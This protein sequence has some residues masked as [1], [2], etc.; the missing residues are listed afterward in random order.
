MQ[1]FEGR[2]W[3]LLFLA[4]PVL[5][6]AVF[7]FAIFDIG[8]FARHWLPENIN[9]NGR[10]IDRLFMFILY[11]TGVI[12]VGTSMALF[13]F[14]WKYD[15]KT[16]TTEVTYTH[17]SHT[18]E[19]VW[20][21]LP[22]AALLFI[23]I[24]QMREWS[25]HKMDRP[26]TNVNNR[27][28]L[29]PPLARVT[30]RQFEWRIQYP[31]EDGELDTIDDIHTVNE[32]H[33]PL[34]EEVVIQIESEDVLHSFFLPNMRVKHDLVPGMKQFVWF[35][36]NKTGQYDIVCAELCGWGHYKMRGRLTVESRD[37]MER[38]LASQYEEQQRTGNTGNAE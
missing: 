30:G 6:V 4:V 3:S 16:R 10:V 5:G 23:A 12:F 1:R 8:P 19:V 7:A 37:D 29:M 33:V 11:L 15:T 22:A 25:E 34:N 31:G 24:F 9:E 17:G 36:P 27:V 2:L 13:W 21:V 32:L 38:W 26:T 20:S 35:Q 28:E 14:I 18:L